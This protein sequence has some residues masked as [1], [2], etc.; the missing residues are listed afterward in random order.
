MIVT[1]EPVMRNR[2]I[3]EVS[4]IFATYEKDRLRR[5]ATWIR[6]PGVTYSCGDCSM[7]ESKREAFDKFFTTDAGKGLLS[8]FGR[9]VDVLNAEQEKDGPR[10]Y[11]HRHAPNLRIEHQEHKLAAAIA[12]ARE[13]TAEKLQKED[14]S[15]VLRSLAKLHAPLQAFFEHV[16]INVE[17]AHLR[18]NRLRLLAEAR[19]VMA[20][21]ADIEN[22]SAW[23]EGAA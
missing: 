14:F 9:I 19:R 10:A 11:S 16:T 21:V 6:S 3:I 20:S 15:G 12:R 5:Q 13:E 22:I 4:N 17:N 2:A 7:S 23:D 8:D 18:L 1:P